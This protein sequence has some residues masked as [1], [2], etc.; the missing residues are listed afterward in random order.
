[1][2][3]FLAPHIYKL[4]HHVCPVARTYGKSKGSQDV[5]DFDAQVKVVEVLLKDGCRRKMR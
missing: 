2:N 1:M 4:C 5:D 3:Y